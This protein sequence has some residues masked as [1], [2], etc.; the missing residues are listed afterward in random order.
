LRSRARWIESRVLIRPRR[1]PSLKTW[2]GFQMLK[3]GTLLTR[4]QFLVSIDENKYFMLIRRIKLCKRPN[5]LRSSFLP[6]R[7]AIQFAWRLLVRRGTNTRN[8]SPK[9]GKK[10]VRE[11]KKGA[12]SRNNYVAGS[13]LPHRR[14]LPRGRGKNAA[15]HLIW[16]SI[17]RI[18]SEAGQ[19]G[20]KT[21]I[22]GKLWFSLK[23]LDYRNKHGCENV[24]Q[25][26]WYFGKYLFKS[27][28]FFILIM[29]EQSKFKIKLY[30]NS[31]TNW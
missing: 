18:E 25:N 14:K 23:F 24:L 31:S 1:T 27:S 8:S 11:N 10:G 20:S 29:H 22:F 30:L 9:W 6:P 19:F 4:Q 7:H 28:Q 12:R 2:P 17:K 26:W 13:V 5:F 3:I 15:D 21:Q 16:L